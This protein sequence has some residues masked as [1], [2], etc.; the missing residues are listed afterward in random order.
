[1]IKW[2]REEGLDRNGAVDLDCWDG[3]VWHT[4]NVLLGDPVV[5]LVSYGI[6]QCRDQVLFDEWNEESLENM[7]TGDW[8][9]GSDVQWQS[10]IERL[11]QFVIKISF[12]LTHL[13]EF[14][15]SMIG[16]RVKPPPVT[17]DDRWEM[18]YIVS[19]DAV[20]VAFPFF[21]ALLTF[22]LSVGT[23]LSSFIFLPLS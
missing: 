22:V 6:T 7:Y 2:V 15:C 3:L 10:D 14:C 11:N 16:V 12:Y 20:H 5:Y 18:E 1:M 9:G 19:I 23:Q 8:F 21:T 13:N 4:L 17:S